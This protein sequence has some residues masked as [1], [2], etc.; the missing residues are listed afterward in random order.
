MADRAALLVALAADAA[1]RSR[2]QALLARFW[3]DSGIAA[4]FADFGFTGVALDVRHVTLGFGQ[5]GIAAS[6]LGWALLVTPAFWW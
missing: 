4:L 5:L 6:T 3:R 2:V 1:A